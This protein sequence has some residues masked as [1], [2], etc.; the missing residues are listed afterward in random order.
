MNLQYEFY[1][2]II[3]PIPCICVVFVWQEYIDMLIFYDFKG[4]L[5]FLRR[6]FVFIPWPSCYNW[7]TNEIKLLIVLR[8]IFK[9]TCISPVN[10][11]QLEKVYARICFPTLACCCYRLQLDVCK[12]VFSN[13]YHV[14]SL[15][16]LIVFYAKHESL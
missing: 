12:Q 3:F 1:M 6:W 8:P 2:L 7:I 10:D 13:F 14:S 5:F 11:M 9:G 4:Q 15:K 16:L